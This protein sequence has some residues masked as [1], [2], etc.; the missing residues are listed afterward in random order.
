MIGSY[1]YPQRG[2]TSGA[3][4][5]YDARF[6]VN[7]NTDAQ[8]VGTFGVRAIATAQD[9]FTGTTGQ[10]FANWNGLILAAKVETAAPKEYNAQSL[11]PYRAG[12]TNDW[13]ADVVYKGRRYVTTQAWAKSA[14]NGLTEWYKC[15]IYDGDLGNK[16]MDNPIKLVVNDDPN[17]TKLTT[18]EIQRTSDDSS[19]P[20]PCVSNFEDWGS[21]DSGM[22]PNAKG[23][24]GGY[25][26]SKFDQKIDQD[27]DFIVTNNAPF[28][29][30]GTFSVIAPTNKTGEHSVFANLNDLS[31]TSGQSTVSEKAPYFH[32]RENAWRADIVYNG[33]RYLTTAM[34]GENWKKCS[35]TNIERNYIDEKAPIKLVVNGDQNRLISLDVMMPLSEKDKYSLGCPIYLEDRGPVPSHCY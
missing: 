9:A 26:Y 1:Y 28:P 2:A 10:I 5:E 33:R 6:I 17:H 25:Y 3:I 13:M 8:I 12:R 30:I 22:S 16:N 20:F 14:V 24:T 34:F 23:Y 32:L 4:A 21:I 31:L 11:A 15:N 35:I 27:I 18:L 29:F 19:K 7:N